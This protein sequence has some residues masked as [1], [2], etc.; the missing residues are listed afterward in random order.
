MFK[1]RTMKM[2]TVKPSYSQLYFH[3]KLNIN[4]RRLKSKKLSN[5]TKEETSKHHIFISWDSVI[6][7][8]KKRYNN[9]AVRGC[10]GV[11]SGCYIN[12]LWGF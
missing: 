11:T 1:P 7:R 5:Q 9:F 3:R 6:E 8:I 4:K 12:V 10:H 2:I